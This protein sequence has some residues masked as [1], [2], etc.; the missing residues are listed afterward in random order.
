M[1]P[2]REAVNFNERAETILLSVYL[3][4]SGSLISEEAS[5]QIIWIW[6]IIWRG[7]HNRVTRPSSERSR[8]ASRISLYSP[9][10][11]RTRGAQSM[12]PVSPNH[13]DASEDDLNE[14]SEMGVPCNGMLTR[15]HL[16]NVLNDIAI[17]I[18]RLSS[19]SSSIAQTLC[20]KREISGFCRRP[21]LHGHLLM[22]EKTT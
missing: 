12:D 16:L 20:R 13:T 21:W 4:D 1:C 10:E 14:E 9:T 18:P 15:V 8:A 17:P 6:D 11:L 2:V 7:V 5:D 22:C 3:L 19:F